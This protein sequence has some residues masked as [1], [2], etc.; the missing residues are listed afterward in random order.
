MIPETIEQ[1][2]ELANRRKWSKTIMQ[3]YNIMQIDAVRRKHYISRKKKV[4]KRL[5]RV[6]RNNTRAFEISNS[7]L[8]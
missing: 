6:G 2:I 3:D 7:Q 5:T 4:K 1:Y 8:K